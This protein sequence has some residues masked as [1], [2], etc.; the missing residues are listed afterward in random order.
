M[1]AGTAER[2]AAATDTPERERYYAEVYKAFV[3]FKT[4]AGESTAGL[5][6]ERFAVKL[7]TCT[8]DLMRRPGV[9]DVQFSVYLKDGAV[10]L[11]AR[12]A[13]G[14]AAL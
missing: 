11:K 14:A 5:T 1:T 4:T 9:A 7:R 12:V 8:A 10:A 3:E 6:F 2:E 13:R